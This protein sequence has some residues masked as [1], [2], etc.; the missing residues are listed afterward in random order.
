MI[1]SHVGGD[2]VAAAVASGFDREPGP[3]L[4]VDLGTNCEVLVG[5]RDRVVAT[6]AAAGPAFEGVSIRCGMRAAPGAIDVVSFDQGA[7]RVHTI[8]ERP[9]AGLCGSALIDVVAEM[10]RVGILAPS[11]YLRKAQEVPRGGAVCRP[12]GRSGWPGRFP[13]RGGGR[14]RGA[15]RRD[16]RARCSRAAAGERVHARGNHPRVP[17]PGPRPRGPA[18]GPGGGRVRQL[19]AEGQRD[20]DST[21]SAC[22]PRAH[23]VRRQRGRCRRP[24]GRARPRRARAGRGFR[25]ACRVPSTSRHTGTTRTPSCGRCRS[26]VN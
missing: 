9:A 22:G 7:V 17:A 12:A 8:G 20:E 10:L 3:R 11:G 14:R 18:R 21:G 15:R 25:P 26:K 6:S 5:W 23:P 16:Y 1:R 2:A 4:L 13:P 24:T 19:P